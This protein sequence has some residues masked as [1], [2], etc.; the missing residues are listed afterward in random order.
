MKHDLC[1]NPILASQLSD[2]DVSP[3]FIHRH[4][5][6]DATLAYCIR[7][8]PSS[9][10]TSP[11]PFISS[12]V[13]LYIPLAAILTSATPSFYFFYPPPIHCYPHTFIWYSCSPSSSFPLSFLP[14]SL[15]PP[16]A[17]QWVYHIGACGGGWVVLSCWQIL[18][19][20]YGDRT[21]AVKSGVLL[22]SPLGLTHLY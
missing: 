13:C 18:M 19:S 21:D 6:Q 12:S 15:S 8:A 22:Y 10:C 4:I 3:E 7:G 17:M 1:T 9:H 2:T 16:S 20:S 14:M 5:C 11:S